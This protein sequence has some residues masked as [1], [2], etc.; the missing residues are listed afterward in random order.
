MPTGFRVRTAIVKCL[1]AVAVCGL[2]CR[3]ADL[4]RDGDGLT[5]YEERQGWEVQIE[6]GFGNRS[7][8]YLV[9]SDPKVADTDGDGLD[10][11]REASSFTD[12]R[13]S[14]TDGDGLTDYEEQQTFLSSPTDVDSDNDARG[15]EGDQTPNSKLF[16]GNEL[17]DVKTSP[18]L[19]DTDGDGNSDYTE[20]VGSGFN[21]RLAEVPELDLQIVG[22]PLITLEVD[23]VES[24]ENF[25]QTYSARMTSRSSSY[26]TSDTKTTG[27]TIGA[28][29]SRTVGAGASFTPGGIIPSVSASN[30][31]SL[32]GSVTRQRVR[33]TTRQSAS[34][35]R[36]EHQ[37]LQQDR[38]SY[39]QNGAGIGAISMSVRLSNVGTRTFVLHDLSVTALTRNPDNPASFKTVGTLVPVAGAPEGGWDL[40]PNDETGAI[41]VKADGL[42]GEL[43]ESLLADPSGLM[44]E[45]AHYTLDVFDKE[46]D[47]TRNFTVF[48]ED[49]WA[50]NAVVVVDFGEG[51]Q[52]GDANEVVSYLVATNVYRN[53]DGSPAGLML[54]EALD[55]IGLPSKTVPDGDRTILTSLDGVAA[56]D[57]SG[58]YVFGYDDAFGDPTVRFEDLPLLNRDR[59]TLAYLTDRDGDGMFAREEHFFGTS[60]ND[61]DD[62][63]D[64][65]TDFEEAIAGWE[66]AVVDRVP[67]PVTSD[68]RLYDTD[69]DGLLDAGERRAGSDPRRP[70]T[71]LEGVWDVVD[72]D[73]TDPG[74]TAGCP[75]AVDVM[76]DFEDYGTR[77]T[78]P[79]I[80][81]SNWAFG[82]DFYIHDSGSNKTLL[83]RD[84]PCDGCSSYFGAPSHLGL[85]GGTGEFPWECVI[86]GTL[87]FD[88]LLR[89]D[90]GAS[91]ALA[92]GEIRLH[93]DGDELLL[94]DL[95]E[96]A[97]EIPTGDFVNYTV[98]LDE[99]QL[100]T[101]S[102]ETL[103]A[104][105]FEEVF[106][107][108]DKLYIR[109]HVWSLG[110]TGTA[111]LDNVR[112]SGPQ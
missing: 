67:Y 52:N 68:P 78:W 85:P 77:S 11:R 23:F 35:A 109:G 48:E 26:S 95:F 61:V 2:G 36:S 104:E 29:A 112:V 19:A 99:T 38:V 87:T 33:N 100:T 79:A 21:P 93:G 42:D 51:R 62:D 80:G 24:S 105:A 22:D 74:V 72:G 41:E 12:P 102:G 25:T 81:W 31:L 75:A 92:G 20:V 6:D 53:P 54:A 37:H 32:S 108:V 107:R 44:F 43:V 17:H 69:G 16:D 70:D 1:C 76:D 34:E 65:L 91:P 86:G 101:P 7:E 14:D 64:G 9:R 49:M 90:A 46:T 110:Q 96:S 89:D 56:D 73:P 30:T 66:V 55:I 4:D 97:D 106:S 45:V 60:D 94:A 88:L 3:P 8:P 58:W 63:G 103:S 111:Y 15:A 40:G 71:D 27:F 82:D 28:G 10:D 83:G 84:F 18:T 98:Q 13:K 39:T 57:D 50:R 5:D 47:T 59:I